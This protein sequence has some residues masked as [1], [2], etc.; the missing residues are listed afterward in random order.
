MSQNELFETTNTKINEFRTMLVSTLAQRDSVTLD[1]I[2]RE[3]SWGDLAQYAKTDAEN[4]ELA[5]LSDE[6]ERF[7]DVMQKAENAWGEE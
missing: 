7:G 3:D 6:F 2:N 5:D 1:A 4:P